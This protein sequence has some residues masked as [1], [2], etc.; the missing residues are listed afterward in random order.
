MANQFRG[1]RDKTFIIL[2]TCLAAMV[3]SLFSVLYFSPSFHANEVEGL[4][5]FLTVTCLLL[6]G[7]ALGIIALA[8]VGLF[9]L[10]EFWQRS[11]K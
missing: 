10:T 3:S 7:Y 8:F 9:V 4:V 11:K 6:V 5:L 1:L 2:L